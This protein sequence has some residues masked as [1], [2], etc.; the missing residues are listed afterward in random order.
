MG[1]GQDFIMNLLGK[2]GTLD[3]QDV[4]VLRDN[5]LNCW[6]ITLFF[7]Q[8]ATETIVKSG[9]ADGNSVVVHGG[10][11]GG[12]ISAHLIGQYPVNHCC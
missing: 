10:S 12:F 2:C 5:G 7:M 4:H 1:F 3:I 9:E 6:K 11:H 8:F